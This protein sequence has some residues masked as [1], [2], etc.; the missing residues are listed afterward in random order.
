MEKAPWNKNKT[1]EFEICSN[2]KWRWYGH[3]MWALPH[4]HLCWEKEIQKKWKKQRKPGGWKALFRL[5]RKTYK[6]SFL[7][8]SEAPLWPKERRP[9]GGGLS[10]ECQL[11][12]GFTL[13][14]RQSNFFSTLALCKLH[15]AF[16]GSWSLSF[17][18]WMS[19]NAF[20]AN[21]I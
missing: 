15:Q 18:W 10:V 12:L 4:C 1:K 9:Q 13:W 11:A 17:H 5:E 8:S 6:H 16:L 3:G 21:S 14:K 7:A 20:L 2:T 19:F